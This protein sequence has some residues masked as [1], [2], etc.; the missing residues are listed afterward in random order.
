MFAAS[1]FDEALTVVV[2]VSSCCMTA[3]AMAVAAAAVGAGAPLCEGEATTA[4]ASTTGGT[5]VP[6]HGTA[7]FSMFQS[8]AEQ[9]VNLHINLIHGM[10]IAHGTPSVLGVG[11]PFSSSRDVAGQAMAQESHMLR[12]QHSI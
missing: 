11:A 3:V 12:Q 9:T 2:M 1:P 5:G 7:N 8:I 6:A 10:P 4:G